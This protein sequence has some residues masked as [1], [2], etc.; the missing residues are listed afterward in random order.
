MKIKPLALLI[1]SELSSES[2][3]TCADSRMDLPRDE[4]CRRALF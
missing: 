1:H 2:S 3:G 4:S